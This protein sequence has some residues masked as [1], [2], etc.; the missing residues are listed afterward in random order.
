MHGLIGL[1]F[2]DTQERTKWKVRDVYLCGG[3]EDC[4][5]DDKEYEVW[6]VEYYPAEIR[7]D[8]GPSGAGVEWSPVGWIK[9]NGPCR[10]F[11]KWISE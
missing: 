3:D 4:A 9:G 7:S 8:P 6:V 11:V 10:K 2:E 5:E 1:T